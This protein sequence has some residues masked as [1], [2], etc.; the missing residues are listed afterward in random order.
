MNK[1]EA[2]GDWDN[3]NKLLDSTPRGNFGNMAV[4]FDEMEIIPK[5][6]G[7]LRWNKDTNA[8][9][10]DASRGVQKWVPKKWGYTLL[11]NMFVGSSRFSSPEIEIRALVE[12]QMLHHRAIAESMGFLFGSE[13]KI[14]ATGGASVNKSILQVIADVF[15]APV[16]QQVSYQFHSNKVFTNC[17]HFVCR[18]R[19]RRRY[20]VPPIELRM[21]IILINTA[22]YKQWRIIASIYWVW[23][24]TTW[25]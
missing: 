21:V 24:R 23:P 1:S 7:T 3:F 6:K 15:N 14:L 19:V 16:Y 11:S 4:H 10:P 17:A 22:R 18:L 20:L 5:V 12:G 25:N 8:S 2:S 9:S 13:A